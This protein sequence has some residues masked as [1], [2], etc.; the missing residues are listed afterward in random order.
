MIYGLSN[1]SAELKSHY[2]IP[3]LIKKGQLQIHVYTHDLLRDSGLDKTSFYN[4]LFTINKN[5][6]NRIVLY[7][8]GVYEKI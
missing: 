7:L 4:L 1:I 8:K 5:I 6:D 2:I 3:S